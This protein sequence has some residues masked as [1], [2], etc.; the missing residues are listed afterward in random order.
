MSNIEVRSEEWD[1]NRKNRI[2]KFG[3]YYDK[4]GQVKG[5][6]IN[7]LPDGYCGTSRMYLLVASGEIS[8]DS[9]I[10]LRQYNNG[11]KWQSVKLSVIGTNWDL[12]LMNI[13]SQWNPDKGGSWNTK[14]P[15][16]ITEVLDEG[17]R[18]RFYYDNTRS[19]ALKL[20]WMAWGY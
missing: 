16:I 20:Q 14:P 4:W 19:S 3:D 18:Y 15:E 10:D 9:T 5:K 17:A 12:S 1:E 13:D 2:N 7:T 8:N 6:F 11:K